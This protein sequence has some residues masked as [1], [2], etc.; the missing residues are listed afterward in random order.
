ML[1]LYCALFSFIISTLFSQY[2]LKHADRFKWGKRAY[3]ER[4]KLH[5]KGVPRLGGIAIYLSLYASISILVLL[6]GEHLSGKELKLFGIFLSSTML[7]G[8]GIY[9]DLIKR[10]SYKIKFIV[11]LISALVL[12]F[13]GYNVNVV[14][15]PLGGSIHIGILGALFVVLWVLAL[16]NAINLIDG[17]DGLACGISLMVAIGFF[18]ISVNQNNIFIAGILA[19]FIGASL[20]FLRYNFYPAK[21]F[22]GDSGSLFLGFILALVAME[23]SLK[24][25]TA[26]SL[27][28][29]LLTLIIPIASITFTF[30][31]RLASAKNPFKADRMHLH[32]RLIRAG[33][34]HRD[35]VLIF[36]NITFLYVALGVFCFFMPKRYEINIIIFA[37]IAMWWIY[38]WALHFINQKKSQKNRKRKRT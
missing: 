26:I 33:I 30:S 1:Y 16:V 6:R 22:L 24:R 14:S 17:L 13:V 20:G 31:R 7:V 18:I 29:P 4:V 12:V 34:S 35:T 36:Y 38:M 2:L 11:Q 19:I 9:D 3:V 8:I 23:S 37:G 25:T 32:Y 10:L 5:K 27:I 15:S 28:V 21:L